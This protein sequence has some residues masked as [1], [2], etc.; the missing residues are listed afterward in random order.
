MQKSI[1]ILPSTLVKL[2]IK[3]VPN[4]IKMYISFLQKSIREVKSRSYNTSKSTQHLIDREGFP[5]S[6]DR[7]DICVC[8]EGIF[9]DEYTRQIVQAYLHFT[10]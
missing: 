6:T 10:R 4:S 9:L 8:G 7:G 1:K 5:H 3:H 2:K